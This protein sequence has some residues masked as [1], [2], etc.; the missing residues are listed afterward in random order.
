MRTWLI[1]PAL[2]ICAAATCGI[3]A[4]EETLA[5]VNG[6]PIV[7]RDI[8]F[9]LAVGGGDPLDAARSRL[10]SPEKLDRLD[11]QRR[12]S[13]FEVVIQRRLILDKARG[14]YHQL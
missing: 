4:E 8:D 6:R 1:L 10:L 3:C 2:T 9:F 13:A 14:K 5:T 11:R 7:P 12:A